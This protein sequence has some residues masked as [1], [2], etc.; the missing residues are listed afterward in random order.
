MSFS[1]LQIFLISFVFLF[2]MISA[3]NYSPFF[4]TKYTNK[5]SSTLILLVENTNFL[6][7]NEY[8]SN[9]AQ[10]YTLIG[11]F[12]KP[13]LIYRP[14]SKLEISSGFFF[15]HYFGALKNI[16]LEPIF[17]V[18][19]SPTQF[20]SINF[21]TLDGTINHKLPET[22]Y[23]P[24]RYITQN[25][26]NGIQFSLNNKNVE[27][28]LWIDWQQF[29][30][31]NSPYPE[32]FCIGNNTTYK[33]FSKNKNQL[34]LQIGGTIAHTGGQI[35]ASSVEVK[36]IV[37]TISGLNFTFN[38]NLKIYS[39]YHTSSDFSPQKRLPY[40]YGYGILSGFDY[41][42]KNINFNFEHWFANC[43][44]SEFGSPIYQSISQVRKNY[45]E[46]K[47][48]II[49]SHLFWHNSNRKIISFGVGTDLYFDLY[50]KTFDYSYNFYIKTNIDL[51]LKK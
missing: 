8:F 51:I 4:E 43:Y 36:S 41:N 15:Q 5:D 50:N 45:K 46:N 39:I 6:K 18:K 42:F 27:S 24:E 29:I 20:F 17:A 31:K 47:R 22:I 21:G 37:N 34:N 11:Y 7:N 16:H 1:R 40:L 23:D 35:D 48:A 26:E 28:Q 19:Y 12:I 38:N 9:F 32:K 13:K 25:T 10:G 33:V 30:F 14:F 3:Q 44:F 2:Q 49:I